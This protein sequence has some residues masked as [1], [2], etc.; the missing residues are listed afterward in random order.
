[1]SFEL[2]KQNKE[3]NPPNLNIASQLLHLLS[4]DI[5]FSNHK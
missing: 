5:V 2:A 3:G 1:M 4:V